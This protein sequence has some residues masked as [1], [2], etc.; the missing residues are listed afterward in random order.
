MNNQFVVYGEPGPFSWVVYG[1]R[2]SIHVEPSKNDCNVQG[3][4]P[5]KWIQ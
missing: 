5:Y 3:N 1:K 4:G 2:G